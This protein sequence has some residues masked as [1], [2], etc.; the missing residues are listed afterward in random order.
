MEERE[1]VTVYRVNQD[2]IEVEKDS[3]IWVDRSRIDDGVC[4]FKR[5][6]RYEL[7][8]QGYV[9]PYS[10]RDL[11]IGGSL[12]EGLDLLLQGGE[13]Y[14]AMEVAVAHYYDRPSDPM[15]LM[16]EQKE[17]LMLDD[18]HMVQGFLFAFYNTY[19]PEILET[20]K[21]I[22]IEEEINWLLGE[23][24]EPIYD[25]TTKSLRD[26]IVV[27]SRP[28]GVWEHINSGNYW[29]S[30]HKSAGQFNDIS[31]QKL[32]VDEQRFLE[33]MAI[34]AKYGKPPE[35]S[36]YNYFIKGRKEWDKTY[37]IER[38]TTGIIRPYLNRKMAL[39]E[40]MPEML[41]YVGKWSELEPGNP[42]PVNGQ[43]GKAFERV[44][45]YEEMDYGTYLEWIRDGLVPRKRDYLKELVAGLVEEYFNPDI[46]LEDMRSLMN[47]EEEWAQKLY[48]I[49]RQNITYHTHTELRR[50]KSHCFSW[51][52]RCT[53][54]DMCWKGRTIE[55]MVAEGKLI[56][57]PINHL[58]EVE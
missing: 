28:D 27:M 39:G 24:V 9:S 49:G 17:R 15:G 53:Y 18:A 45:I 26:K 10:N 31:N 42:V 7:H 38:Y 51:Q 8:G 29:H 21:I 58:Q 5:F 33:S 41:S 23:L 35:G 14:K 52:R 40:I 34:W 32:E 22:A 57:R 20:Y 37:G 1:K 54:Y 13:L 47:Q 56:V 55:G 2:P 50:R 19:L 46:A 30:S 11:D 6:Y 16:L 36:L 48:V 44:A 3:I 4:D 25:H 12:H 43:V